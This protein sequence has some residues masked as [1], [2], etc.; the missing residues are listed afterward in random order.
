MLRSLTVVRVLG[1]MLM[2]FSATYALPLLASVIYQ[3]GAFAD[4]ALAMVWS[5]ATSDNRQR[6]SKPSPAR[7]LL[8]HHPDI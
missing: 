6:M 8:M 1:M 3:Y 7:T 5:A 4:F 2:V